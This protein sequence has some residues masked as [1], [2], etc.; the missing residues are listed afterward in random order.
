[1]MKKILALLL[2]VALSG[3][4]SASSLRNDVQDNGK[5]S[6]TVGKVQRD[7]KLGMTNAQVAEILGS[8]NVVTTD[9][10]R[11]EVWVYDKVASEVTASQ[12]GGGWTLILFG[13]ERNSAA[14]STTQRTLT[15]VIKF[16]KES[17]VRDFA[18][19]SSKF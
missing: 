1:M 11:C 10:N 7:I 16:D 15:I 6:L 8:P 3:C 18:Y 12:S 17:R 13:S 2:V 14:T 4:A 9:E 19:N 5:N